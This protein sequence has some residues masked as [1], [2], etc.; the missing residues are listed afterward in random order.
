M[1]FWRGFA[2][3]W[4]STLVVGSLSVSVGLFLLVNLFQGTFHWD[5]FFALIAVTLA[6]S[7][8]S[9]LPVQLVILL[10]LRKPEA[11]LHDFSFWSN[12]RLHYVLA[13]VLTMLV[14]GVG[15]TLWRMFRFPDASE[16]VVQE[17]GGILILLQFIALFYWPWGLYFFGRFKDSLDARS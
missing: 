17:V 13:T 14:L 10:K 2:L 3:H 1:R 15:F 6:V 12:F 8:L 4:V 5:G 11:N 7:A 9:S 16:D